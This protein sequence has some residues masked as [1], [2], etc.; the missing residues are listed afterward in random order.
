M[1]S[2]GDTIGDVCDL[3]TDTDG[4]GYG[5]PNFQN[6]VCEDDNCPK[7]Y[8]PDQAEKDRGDVDC[9]DGIDVLDVIAVVNH[10]VAAAP[11]AGEPFERADCNG[12]GGVDVLDALGMINVILG[13]GHCGPMT[14]H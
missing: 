6:T 7:V 9:N 13:L 8:N 10:I 12:D 1:D 3:C 2:D 11:L 5:D 4:D 14:V